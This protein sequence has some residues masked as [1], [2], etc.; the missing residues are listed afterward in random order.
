[1]A[2]VFSK[3]L[4]TLQSTFRVAKGTL[5]FSALT[6]SRTFTWP[7][8]GGGVFVSG[9]VVVQLP[10]YV[11]TPANGTFTLISKSG[12]AVTITD[13]K[14]VKT[15]AGTLTLTVSI[16]GVAVTGLSAI[17]VTT[18]AQDI[19]ATALNALA[20]GGRLTLTVASVAGA[21]DLEFT[22]LGVR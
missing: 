9:S 7:N 22:L 17:A 3:L 18:T 12:V 15:S 21:A 2:T 16:G 13:I 11:Q 10:G 5:D 4:G 20:V 6:L 1:M 19:P 8:V 14:G